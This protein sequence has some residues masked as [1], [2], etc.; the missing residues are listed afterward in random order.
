MVI[1]ECLSMKRGQPTILKACRFHEYELRSVVR[2]AFGFAILIVHPQVFHVYHKIYTPDV[3]DT[4][5]NDICLLVVQ[6]VW[7]NGAAALEK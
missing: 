1:P 3:Q 2:R 5:M 6:V 4:I 7:D